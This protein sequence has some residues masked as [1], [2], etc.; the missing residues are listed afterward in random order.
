[1]SCWDLAA[2]TVGIRTRP[3]VTH[4]CHLRP[5]SFPGR[6]GACCSAA[7]VLHSA[8][9]RAREADLGPGPA[10]AP[11]RGG[12][13]GRGGIAAAPQ[14]VGARARV[15]E[16]VLQEG[17]PADILTYIDGA[18]LIDLWEDLVL[19]RGVRSAW[20]PPISRET[21]ALWRRAAA[22]RICRFFSS[23]WPG[24]SSLCPPVRAFC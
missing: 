10:A 17:T 8:D 11:R 21:G 13:L 23:R 14:L 2:N 3:E 16:I 12:G 5:A 4:G 24:C 20:A 15:Y 6:V 7:C 18:L 1:V 19:P 22:S 9:V